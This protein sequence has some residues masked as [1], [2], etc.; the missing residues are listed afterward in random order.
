VTG[1]DQTTVAGL[2]EL[3]WQAELDRTP[4]EPITDARPDLTLVDAYAIQAHNVR[5]RIASGRQVRGRRLGRTSRRPRQ[6]VPG[7]EEPD[8]GVLLDDMFV[9]EGVEIPI[10]R[11]LQ[12]RVTATLAF[13]L[14]SDFSGTGLTV[15]DALTAIAGVLPAI[16]VAD[17]RIADWRVRPPDSVADNASA[18]RVVLGTRLTPVTAVD[19]RLVGLLLHRNGSPI[20]SA[21]GAAA[22]GSPIRCV[23]R[24]AG[25][26]AASGRRLGRGDVVLAGPLHR[27]VP[28]RPGDCFHAEFAH[29]GSVTA[30]FSGG[31]D[32]A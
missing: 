3:L 32:G 22:L 19:L 18:G 25:E 27:L 31:G 11:L 4:I 21:A 30:Q 2:A 1:V 9:D 8:F 5:R 16:E 20:E 14:G 6:H 17:S 12:P 28:A 26:L 7:T 10:E 13:V 24:V 23:T 29:L 15:A